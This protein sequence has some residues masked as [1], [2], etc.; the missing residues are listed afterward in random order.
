MRVL[1]LGEGDLSGPARYLASVLKW[2]GWAFDHRADQVKIP[3]AWQRPGRYDVIIL[4][5]YRYA[6]FTPD[7]RRWLIKEVREGGTGLL[8]IGGWA[9][10]TGL[11]GHY[12]G[13]DI[14]DLLPVQCMTEDDRVNCASGSVVSIDDLRL[15]S[16]PI[17]CGYHR[18]RVKENSQVVFSLRDLKF[19]PGKPPIVGEPH[20]LH[21]LGKSGMAWTAAFLT[22]C[23]P[24][25]AGGL[26]DWGRKRVTVNLPGGIETEVGEQ[27][28]KFFRAMIKTLR[29][30][31]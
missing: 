11:V 20:P 22:D 25:W 8:M 23:A 19:S 16:L 17:V 27:Y 18:V 4:S 5:D 21:V 7:A 30:R 15:T 12:A 9:S 14:E 26:V 10:F 1:F 29:K 24:H 31:S 28:L 3:K 2:S 6:S 13:T